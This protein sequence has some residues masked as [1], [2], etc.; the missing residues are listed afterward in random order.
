[1]DCQVGFLMIQICAKSTLGSRLWLC[2]SGVIAK[3][4]QM[5]PCSLTL[6]ILGKIHQQVIIVAIASNTTTPSNSFNGE[7]VRRIL[8]W[9]N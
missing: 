6:T 8:R 1:M 9:K 2:G 7:K 4:L 5:I 3:T